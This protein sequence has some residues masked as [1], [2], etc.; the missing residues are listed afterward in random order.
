M[1]VNGNKSAQVGSWGAWTAANSPAKDK[2]LTDGAV[3]STGWNGNP[4]AGVRETVDMFAFY[5]RALSDAEIDDVNKKLLDARWPSTVR[6]E[7]WTVNGGKE[8]W[9]RYDYSVDT[10][11]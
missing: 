9:Q 8:S 10:E 5:N 11:L 3:F 6:I 1:W 2:V 7:G 4:E